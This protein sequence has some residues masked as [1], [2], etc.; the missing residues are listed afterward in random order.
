MSIKLLEH[1]RNELISSG[2]AANTPEFCRCWLGR[3]EGYIRTL[4]HSR[5]EPSVETLAVCAHK[6][7]YY[8][9]RMR[10]SDDAE[11]KA[12]VDRFDRL[13]SLCELAI[14]RQA[15]SVW[16]APTRMSA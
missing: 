12:W 11:H 13:R 1:I 2:A 3:S 9:D 8:A 5:I 6:L 10:H 7:G 4:R 14:A 16:R 15:E